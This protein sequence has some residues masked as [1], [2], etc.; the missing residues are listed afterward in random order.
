MD[1]GRRLGTKRNDVKSV[2]IDFLQAL[3]PQEELIAMLILILA[4]IIGQ[5]ADD[6]MQQIEYLRLSYKNNKDKFSFGEF[7]FDYTIGVAGSR[8]DAE[9][10]VFTSSVQEEG[11]YIFDGENARYE[12]VAEP[13]AIAAVTKWLDDRRNTSMAM[14]F[15]M[16]TDGKV[17]FLDQVHT[18][19]KG[20]VLIHQ[21][22][23]FQG[24]GV[25]R[26]RFDFPLF[27]GSDSERPYDLFS[28]LA[29]IK[30]GSA[31]LAELDLDSHL[32]GHKV[33]KVSFNYKEGRCTYWLD[34][35]RGS[36]PLRILD[37]YN[38]ADLDVTFDFGEVVQIPNAGWLPRRMVHIVG[39]GDTVQRLLVKEVDAQHKP[40][41]TAFALDFP[42]PVRVTDGAR[43][44]VYPS[45][46]TW[47]LLH[48]PGRHSPGTI[49]A[50]PATYVSPSELP[51]EMDAGPSWVTIFFLAILVFLILGSIFLIR[52]RKKRLRGA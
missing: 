13:K 47:S 33:C 38:P 49:T 12:L 43:K 40:A 29:W 2:R 19:R 30:E 31:S 34:L 4:A 6:P 46:K 45:S 48:L 7:R 8:S 20:T 3:I 5:P 1:K 22:E 50:T 27:L 41:G 14:V 21:P 51:G 42:K 39:N 11:F 37:H 32:D 36:V 9:A 35:N 52:M 28:N 25:Y 15:R 44:L 10:G 18:N 26:E 17:T 16:L 24:T 23:I